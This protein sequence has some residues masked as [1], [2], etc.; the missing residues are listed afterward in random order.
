VSFDSP[1]ALVAL[2]AV[3]VLVALYVL[4]ER[5]RRAAGARF[6]ALG[7]LPNLLEHVPGWRRHLP[8]ALLLVALAA[9]IVGVARPHATV[10]V[11]RKDATVLLALDV[12]RS[13]SATDV[14]PSR[15]QAAKAA[16]AKFLTEVPKTF[17]VGIIAIGSNATVVLPPTTDRALATSALATLRRSEG[18]VLGDAVALSVDV[19]RRQRT[20]SGETIPT[21]VL[22][23]SDGSDQGSRLK[24]QAAA[25]RARAAHIP[26]YTTLVGTQNGIVTRALTGGY[27]EQIR[28]P[29]NPATLRTIA[30][31]SGGEFFQAPTAEKLR[32]VYKQ[33]GTRLGHHKESREISDAF[34]GGA[35]LLL[36]A[37]GA[38]S[39]LWFRR[40]P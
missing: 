16:A 29:A 5:R 37:G 34:A 32:D 14:R 28:V 10:S 6:A 12:S 30:Q 19:G 31:S 25:T 8:I 40:L 4:H 21:A 13:M 18:T 20:S 33:L 27:Q 36:L 26:V 7:L 38:L 23:I 3:P 24:P 22:V 15:I 9:M 11:P 39:A 35:A 1:L 2:V 17:R